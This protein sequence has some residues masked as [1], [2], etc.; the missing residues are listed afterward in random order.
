[1]TSKGLGVVKIKYDKYAGCSPGYVV[2]VEP[3]YDGGKI[4]IWLE[5]ENSK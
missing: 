3:G 1:L 2:T 4:A 5:E